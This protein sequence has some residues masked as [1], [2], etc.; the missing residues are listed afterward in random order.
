M[1]RRVVMV[2]ST[3][4]AIAFLYESMKDP[5]SRVTLLEIKGRL[6]ALFNAERTVGNAY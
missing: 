4:N 3:M 5:S 2:S 1:A 6:P